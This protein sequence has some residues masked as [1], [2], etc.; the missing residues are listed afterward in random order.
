MKGMSQ[1]HRE[2]WLSQARQQTS[3]TRG[4]ALIACANEDLTGGE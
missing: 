1:D 3:D 4:I 2:A